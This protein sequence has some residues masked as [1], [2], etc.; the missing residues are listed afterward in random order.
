MP[1]QPRGALHAVSMNV[2]RKLRHTGILTVQ[3]V[4]AILSS[5]GN[6]P[7]TAMGPDG[8][9]EIIQRVTAGR[10]ANGDFA[11]GAATSEA[12]LE[13]LH[14]TT[15]RSLGGVVGRLNSRMPQK[16]K[17]PFVVLQ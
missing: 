5:G 1:S 8:T 6:W 11:L 13:P 17:G 3:V 12:D 2:D 7:C 4:E 14:G 15:K 9:Y 16:G 10:R